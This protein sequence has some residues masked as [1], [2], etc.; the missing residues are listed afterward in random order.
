[1]LRTCLSTTLNSRR[2]ELWLNLT[3]RTVKKQNKK[4]IL[5]ARNIV[6]DLF[7]QLTYWYRFVSVQWRTTPLK[8]TY[9]K[10]FS[11]FY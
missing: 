8:E 10:T 2:R 5:L 11:I 6:V 3:C 1:M 9:G 7:N 4:T